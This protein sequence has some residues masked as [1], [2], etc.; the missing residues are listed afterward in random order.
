MSLQQT[1]RTAIMKPSMSLPKMSAVALAGIAILALATCPLYASGARALNA[2]ATICVYSVLVA[3]YGLLISRSGI[4]SFGHQVFF[5]IGAYG[6]GIALQ[7]FGPSWFAVIIGLGVALVGGGC[8]ALAVALF[9]LRM[10]TIFYAMMTFAVAD[11]AKTFVFQSSTL[12]GGEDGQSYQVPWPITPGPKVLDLFGTHLEFSGRVLSYYLVFSLCALCFA[13]IYRILHSPFGA[14]LKGIK[15]N[16][17]RAE[18]VG[19][20]VPSYRIAVSCIAAIFAIMAGSIFAL[21]TSFVSPNTTFELHV[22]I[23]I[24]LM[25]VIG[26]MGNIFGAIVGAGVVVIAQNYLVEFL[27]SLHGLAAEGTIVARLLDPDRW[28]LWLGIV[29][30]LVVYLL[31]GGLLG[32]LLSRSDRERSS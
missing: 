13:A 2:A 16:P 10:R 19:Y 5:G 30:V 8:L 23:D 12:T 20:H 18:A 28:L 1:S 14:T 4:I 22:M 6:T 3:S 26:G 24:L 25:L 21:W 29:F 31:P 27:G 15:E 7:Q 9:S 17:V 32:T 11:A